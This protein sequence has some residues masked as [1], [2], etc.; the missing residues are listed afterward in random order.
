[1]ESKSMQLK[2]DPTIRQNII[3]ARRGTA[4]EKAKGLV[5]ATSLAATLVSWAAFAQ[6]DAQ[7]ATLDA[8]PSGPVAAVQTTGTATSTPAQSAN[9][10]PLATATATATTQAATTARQTSASTTSSSNRPAAITS[11]RSSR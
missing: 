3:R 10:L 7:T 9:V 11:T 2:P 1:M 5:V 8:T 4:G 6:Q